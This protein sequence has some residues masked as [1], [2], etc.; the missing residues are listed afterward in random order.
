MNVSYDKTYDSLSHV[1]YIIFGER[2]QLTIDPDECTLVS[3]P[4]EYPKVY[5]INDPKHM[6]DIKCNIITITQNEFDAK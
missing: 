2:S 3:E 6:P 4:E 5:K 1:D